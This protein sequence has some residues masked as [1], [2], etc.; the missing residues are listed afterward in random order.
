MEIT[1]PNWCQ[2]GPTLDWL[3]LMTVLTGVGDEEQEVHSICSLCALLPGSD[4]LRK[5][6]ES[7]FKK[8]AVAYYPLRPY[9]SSYELDQI[10]SFHLCSLLIL[11]RSHD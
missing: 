4:Y 6:S 8:L 7:K 9:Y 1:S 10:L 2:E 3:I 11:F 5:P